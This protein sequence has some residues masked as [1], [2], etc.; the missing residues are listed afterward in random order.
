MDEGVT[1]RSFSDPDKALKWL[2]EVA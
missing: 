1:V 2:E